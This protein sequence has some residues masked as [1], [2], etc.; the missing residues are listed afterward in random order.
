M[1]NAAAAPAPTA[2]ARL[3]AWCGLYRTPQD[4][5]LHVAGAAVTHG[6]CPT[7]EARQYAQLEAMFGVAA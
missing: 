6:I 1:Q 4:R 2:L 3:C 5:E 7:C